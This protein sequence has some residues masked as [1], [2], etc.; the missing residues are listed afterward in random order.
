M[1][2]ELLF[3]RF[4]PFNQSEVK[5]HGQKSR[6]QANSVLINFAQLF[7]KRNFGIFQMDEPNKYSGDFEVDKIIPKRTD[8][9]CFNLQF[10]S[11]E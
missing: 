10:P 11:T 4:P 9:F 6:E 7:S 3:D 5:T 2:F 8:F 1:P